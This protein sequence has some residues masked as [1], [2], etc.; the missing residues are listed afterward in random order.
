MMRRLP[1]CCTCALAGTLLDDYDYSAEDSKDVSCMNQSNQ[2]TKHL[3]IPYMTSCV[4]MNYKYKV[5]V[6]P[7]LQTHCTTLFVAHFAMPC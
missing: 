3:R 2:P 5:L 7:E 4:P 1:Q 6:V